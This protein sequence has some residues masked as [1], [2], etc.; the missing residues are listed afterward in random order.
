[1]KI[2]C[3]MPTTEA[4]RAFWPGAVSCFLSQDHWEDLELLVLNET[5]QVELPPVFDYPRVRYA[6]LAEASRRS[7]T[8]G[9]KRNLANDLVDGGVILHWDDDDWSA[10]ARVRRQAELLYASGRAVCGF[11]DL[12]YLRVRDRTLWRYQFQGR[13]PYAT[14]TS[15]CYRKSYW[16]QHPFADRRVGEDSEFALAARKSG[17]LAS[18]ASDGLLVARAHDANTY[19]PEFGQAPFLKAERSVFPEA[20]LREER[21]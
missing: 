8:T 13:P 21:L 15:L 1:M 10:P 19:V 16:E 5:S 12:L 2:T 9:R 6:R 11:H 14:G 4:R 18:V 3:V 17:D 20:F 7:H